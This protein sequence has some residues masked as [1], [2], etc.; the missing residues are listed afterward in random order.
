MTSEPIAR[1]LNTLLPIGPVQVSPPSV[2]SYKPTPAP[3]SPEEFASPVPTHTWLLLFG[4]R[5]TDPVAFVAKDA[6]R[7]VQIGCAFS[8]LSVRHTPPP[9]VAAHS[10]QWPGMHPGSIANPVVRPPAKK[11]LG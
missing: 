5:T 6:E 4:S 10:R 3:L 9:A 8:A 11:L 2:D 1:A 7:N